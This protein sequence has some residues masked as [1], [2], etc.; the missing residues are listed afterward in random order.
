M[1]F[2]KDS[3][4]LDF[5]VPGELRF[6]PKVHMRVRNSSIFGK[7]STAVRQARVCGPLGNQK[8]EPREASCKGRR[9]L[10]HS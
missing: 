4:T 3:E 7:M 8:P 2:T 9:T 1:D 5:D 6:T 10:V